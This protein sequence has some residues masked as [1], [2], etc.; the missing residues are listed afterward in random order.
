MLKIPES[1]EL[2]APVFKAPE[3]SDKARS[4]FKVFLKDDYKVY[5]AC[6]KLKKELDKKEVTNG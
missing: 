5:N 3:L 6:L 4:A 1:V 2:P